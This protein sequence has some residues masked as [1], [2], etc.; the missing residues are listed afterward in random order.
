VQRLKLIVIT[1]LLPFFIHG[2]VS[3]QEK[4]NITHYPLNIEEKIEVPNSCKFEYIPSF[5]TVAVMDF[6]N[7]S[8]FG[9][10]EVYDSTTTKK[11]SAIAGVIV[12]DQGVGLGG[13]KKSTKKTVNVKRKVDAKL[14][15][16]L[17]PLLETKIAQLSGTTIVARN[18]IEKINTEL[19]LQDSGLLDTSSVLEFGK[20]LGAK[21]I[22]TGSIDNVEINHRNNEGAAVAVNNATSKSK[23]SGIQIAGLFGRVLTSIT[24][25]ILI[26]T[27]ITIKVLDVQTGVILHSQ[28]LYDDVNIGKFNNPSYDV[29]IGGIK[30]AIISSLE[31]LNYD[32]SNHFSLRGYITKIKT[33]GNHHLVQV[34]L[35][36]NSNI[37]ANQRFKVYTIEETIDPFT[38]EIRCDKTELPIT[39]RSTSHV[40]QTHCWLKTEQPNCDLKLLQL[41]ESTQDQ[42]GFFE[43]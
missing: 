24:D 25:G 35:G 8:T 21:F 29:Y 23:D 2:C 9:K 37:K 4:V 33:D 41:V 7:N 15:Q 14:S 28:T 30:A 39:L 43:F 16:T 27:T 12:N 32:F 17:T 40:T 36:R 31:K 20:L 3:N 22:V 34:N 26:K 42:G 5:S 11:G 18:D 13:A 6:T 19:K 38:G 1:S 10:A